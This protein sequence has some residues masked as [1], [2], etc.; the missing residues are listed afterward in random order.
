MQSTSNYV[1]SVGRLTLL[2]GL[3][4]FTC[5]ILLA[6]AVN[7]NFDTFA[8]PALIFGD[9]NAAEVEFFR[10]GMITD[11]WGYY[12]LFVPLVFFLFEKMETP[13]RNIFAASGIA[14]AV[15]GAIGAAILTATGTHFLR[16]YL[17]ADAAQQP[18]IK[19]SFL[20][21]YHIVNNGIWNLLEMGLLGIFMFGAAPVL[22]G[23]GKPLYYLT[24]LLG[25]S[26]ILDTV[27]HTFELP[28]LSE[29]GL[30]FYLFF[31][32]IWAAWLGI[33]WMQ[34]RA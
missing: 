34:E 17:Q 27:G 21:V 1:R 16:E 6:L 32:P 7:F 23:Y 29:I 25:V 12:L 30:N 24:I 20:F 9:M 28:V 31:E 14:Y 19:D 2:S 3:L 18:A 13:W 8:Q 26:G 4:A 15:M 5:N 11:L 22:R 10:W 33:R